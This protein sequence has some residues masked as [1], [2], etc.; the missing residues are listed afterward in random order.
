MTKAELI[1]HFTTLP[2]YE[3]AVTT[4]QLEET[5][6]AGDNLYTC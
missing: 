4:P 2:G 5:N 6:V 1:T 3:G